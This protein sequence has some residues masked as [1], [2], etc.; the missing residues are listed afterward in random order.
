MRYALAKAYYEEHGNLNVPPKYI[1]DGVWLSKWLNEQ[2]QIYNGKRKSKK[3][4]QAQV[5]R[6]EA[7]GI[8]WNN[9]SE[10]IRMN[11]WETHFSEC[12]EFYAL[13]G[14]LNIP[15]EYKPQS[16]TNLAVWLVR[17][18]AQYKSGKLSQE[19]IAKL[20]AIGMVLLEQSI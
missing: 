18:R 2:K 5:K 13:H 17:Q 15:S 10:E 19:H 14:N 1:A 12:K 11:A 16:G 7:I 8:S 6:L 3:L 4:T 9:R 20:E